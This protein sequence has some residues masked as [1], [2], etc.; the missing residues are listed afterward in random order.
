M[1][2]NQLWFAATILSLQ[3]MQL[4]NVM[5]VP[6]DPRGVVKHLRR[7]RKDAVPS[8]FSFRPLPK[9]RRKQTLRDNEVATNLPVYGPPTYQTWLEDQLH[10]TKD[11]LDKELSKVLELKTQILCYVN[12]V[13]Y[14]Q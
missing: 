10:I 2:Q 3:T 6:V 12:L 9:C 13:D 11:L 14:L 5:E 1:S 7:L 4:V 8:V